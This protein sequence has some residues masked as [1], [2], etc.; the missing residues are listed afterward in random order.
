MSARSLML[1]IAALL[2]AGTAVYITR[3]VLEA[4]KP[5]EQP[6]VTQAAPAPPPA[7]DTSI[8][9]AA[10]NLP[11]GT[12]LKPE[13]LK[14]QAWPQNAITPAFF[15]QTSAKI[16]DFVGAVVRRGVAAGEPIQATAVVKP[17][18]RGF[19]AAVLKPGMRAISIGVGDVTGIAG[20][21]LPGD[22]VDMLLTHDLPGDDNSEGSKETR[23]ATETV[24]ENIRI[25]AID[26]TLDDIKG[27][28]V[29][30]KVATLEVTP[31]QAEMIAVVVELGRV[32][33]SLRSL[34]KDQPEDSPAIAANPAAADTVGTKSDDEVLAGGPGDDSVSTGGA[35]KPAP[36]VL[37]EPVEEDSPPTRGETYTFDSEVSRLLGRKSTVK[38]QVV[39][40]STVQQMT[41]DR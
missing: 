33:F 19:L 4:R 36:A 10:A 5:A 21:M 17:G 38:V 12:L 16:E 31:K 14:W 18:E 1:F 15:A 41:F 40:G 2:I 34:A 23:H 30:G 13:H 28:P 11:T 25:L 7:A 26:Q 9:V 22:R 20:M 6:A 35:T 39:Q 29:S 27:Q 32:Q 24:L 3:G 8:L 37:P